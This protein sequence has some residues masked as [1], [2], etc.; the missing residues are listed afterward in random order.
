MLPGYQCN[1]T[2]M[3]LIRLSKEPDTEHKYRLT[4][5]KIT[6]LSL[7]SDYQCNQILNVIRLSK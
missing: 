5:L 1:Q 2:T 6:R 4:R 3:D 7:L